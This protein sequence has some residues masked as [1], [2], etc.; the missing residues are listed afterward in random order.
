MGANNYNVSPDGDKW[1]F[2]REGS[3][4]PIKRFDTQKDA[5]DFGRPIAR[6]QKAEFTIRGRGGQIRARD[7][8]GSGDNFPPRG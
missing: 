8:Y 2:Q 4:K 3:S 6:N 5:I 1:K 7:S